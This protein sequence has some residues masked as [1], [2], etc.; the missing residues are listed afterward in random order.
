VNG[1]VPAYD[2]YVFDLDGTLLLG[3]RAL[4]GAA[5]TIA[6][7]RAAGSSVRYLTNKPLER[8]ATYARQLTRLD[9][10]AQPDEVVTSTDALIRYLR[11]H[12][13]GRAALP[14][15]E[16]LV[17]ELLREAG[18]EVT[19]D[20]ASAGVVVVSFDRTFDYAKLLAAY[21]AVRG[22]AVIVATN[23]DPY[24]PT[25][26]GGIPDCAAMLAAIEA[27]TGVKAEAVVGKPS[28]HMAETLLG[29]L[30]VA[31]DRTLL[32]GDRLDTDIAMALRAGM[33]A[34]LVLT[35]AT[36]RSDLADSRWSPTFVLDHLTD[37]LP[38]TRAQQ[39]ASS[40]DRR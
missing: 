26:D 9:I 28:P 11:L 33:D 36:D 22:G 16:P 30:G 31:P 2:G 15:A 4:P 5:A 37:L 19:A 12:H 29:R 20:P 7:L 3:D 13:A 1:V 23:P 6:A 14:V 18:L 39:A 38:G 27:S 21:Q 8:P 32:V 17:T 40:G 25:P 34:A 24:C 10:P 35:G